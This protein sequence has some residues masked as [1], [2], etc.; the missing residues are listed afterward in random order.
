MY[1]PA[2]DSF[3]LS[4]IISK[5]IKKDSTYLDLGCGSGIL[6]ETASKHTSKKNILCSDIDE[7]VLNYVSKKGFKTIHSNLFENIK[8]KFDVISFNAPYLPED[9]NEKGIDT[10][11]GKKGDEVILKFLEQSIAHINKDGKIFL[12]Y[13]SYTPE[14]RI[15]KLLKKLE[16]KYVKK[17]KSI[18][19]EKIIV[20]I[21]SFS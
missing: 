9:K 16:L 20:L 11:G 8:D 18:F 19:F 21:I 4:E 7:E 15:L 6:A 5:Y 1:A 13:S 3:F 10:T 14:S 2:E 17:E 12:L